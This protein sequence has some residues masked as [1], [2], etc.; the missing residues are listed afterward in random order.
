M[1]TLL[2]DWSSD[3]LH[4]L[5]EI[6]ANLPP[7]GRSAGDVVRVHLHAR[8]TET[9]TLELE[10]LPVGSDRSDAGTPRWKVELNVR[11]DPPATGFSTAG[12]TAGSSAGSSAGGSADAE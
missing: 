1:G 12:S 8:I 4:E 5:Q 2:D 10:A 7:H 9:G 11:A 3:E 6:E